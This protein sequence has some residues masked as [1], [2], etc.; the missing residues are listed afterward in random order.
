[1]KIGIL[2]TGRIPD[3]LTDKY[4]DYDQK[5]VKLLENGNFDF[6]HYA[7]LDGIL[8]H[9]PKE[10]DGWLITGSR[11]GVYEDHAWIKPL[12]AFILDAFYADIPLVGICFG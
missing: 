10:A 3:E 4:L 5:F 2:Q 8:P 12:E 11:F 6:I 9:D 1:M 7:I